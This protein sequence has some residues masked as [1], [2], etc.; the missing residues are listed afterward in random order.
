VRVR[1]G[2]AGL[3]AAVL[4]ICGCA[5]AGF[6]R[7]PVAQRPVTWASHAAAGALAAAF[8]AAPSARPAAAGRSAGL[9]NELHLGPLDTLGQGGVA[10]HRQ[11]ASSHTRRDAGSGRI[12]GRLVAVVPGR[13]QKLETC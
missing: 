8:S 2:V 12:P 11:P 3:A 10:E 4:G 7:A 6:T 5:A 13:H 9:D 1:A